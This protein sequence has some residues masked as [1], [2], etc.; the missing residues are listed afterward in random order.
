MTPG[1]TVDI[2]KIAGDQHLAGAD[3]VGWVRQNGVNCAI[4]PDPGVEGGINCPIVVQTSDATARCTVNGDEGAAD[5]NLAEITSEGLGEGEDGAI[6]PGTE[7]KGSVDRAAVIQAGKMVADDAIDVGEETAEENTAIGLADH[8]A[9]G[10]ID[11]V[12]RKRKAGI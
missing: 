2:G 9:D 8:R 4:S 1:D 10:G 3:A 7:I 6:S 11:A 5:V 12:F